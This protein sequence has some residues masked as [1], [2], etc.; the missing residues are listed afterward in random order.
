[1]KMEYLNLNV[2]LNETF[3]GKFSRVYLRWQEI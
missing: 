3:L 2:N 1:M